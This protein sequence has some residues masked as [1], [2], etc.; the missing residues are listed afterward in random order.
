MDEVL[1]EMIRKYLVGKGAYVTRYQREDR[2]ETYGLVIQTSG[3]TVWL[4][5]DNENPNAK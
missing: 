2:S 1:L 4:R 5:A 3:A